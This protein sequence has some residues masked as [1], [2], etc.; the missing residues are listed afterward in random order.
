MKITLDP[1]HG[2]TTNQGYD[3]NYYEGA[4]V[5]RLAVY[6]KEAL[7]EMYKDVEV[8]MTRK[9]VTDNPTLAERAKVAGQSGSSVI[10]SLHTNAASDPA[11]HG[12]S[13]FRSIQRENSVALAGAFGEKIT[14]TMRA[15]TGITYLRGILTRTEKNAQGKTVDWYGILRES[16]KYASVKFAFILEHGFHT[17]PTECAYLLE[18]D[19]LLALAKTEAELLGE[20]FSLEKK[21]EPTPPAADIEYIVKKGDTLYGIAKAYGTTYQALAAYNGIENPSLIRVGQIIR[22]PTAEI[23]EGDIVRLKP[24]VTSYYPDGNPFS[25][26]MHDYDFIV[27][28]TESKGKT[29]YR[30]GY[31]CVLLGNKIDR[32]TGEV[33]GNIKSWCAIA[34][35]ERV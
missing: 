23:K 15:K 12:V 8:F 22:I 30:N 13:V 2:A 17:N 34:Y 14:E 9:A 28:Q 33:G 32:L 10:L 24:D 35:L 3:K 25:P 11:A 20:Y 7:E 5:Y 26:R 19:D 21:D 1:G 6:L 18:D 16:V 4:R 29:V 31:P 27:A